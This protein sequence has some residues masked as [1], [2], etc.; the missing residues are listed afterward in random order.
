LHL[1]EREVVPSRFSITDPC[2]RTESEGDEDE[3]LLDMVDEVGF[4]TI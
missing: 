2:C 1:L 3:A 4:D